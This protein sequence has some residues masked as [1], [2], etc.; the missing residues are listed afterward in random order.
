MLESALFEERQGT[1]AKE[2]VE[3]SA[4]FEKSKSGI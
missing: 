4:V 3:Q 2:I 1:L